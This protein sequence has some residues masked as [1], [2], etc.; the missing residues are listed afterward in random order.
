MQ[1]PA[2]LFSLDQYRV[3]DSIGYLLAR[4]RTKIAKSVDEALAQCGIT[5]AQGSIVYMLST[6]K[7]ATAADL[8]RELYIDAGSMKRMLDRLVLRNLI[9]RTP[10]IADRRLMNLSLT[11]A[12]KVLAEKMPAIYVAVQNR[13]FAGF[14]LEEVGFLKSLLRKFLAGDDSLAP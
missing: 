3:E 14:S 9:A 8:S 10:S 1:E 12:G 13:N 2:P 4:S 5:Y 11:P 7:Y 6:G